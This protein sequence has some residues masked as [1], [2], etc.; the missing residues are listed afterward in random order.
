MLQDEV[1][2]VVKRRTT[3]ELYTRLEAIAQV[4]I[5]NGCSNC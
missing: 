3:E 1:D 4:I 2:S 5:H